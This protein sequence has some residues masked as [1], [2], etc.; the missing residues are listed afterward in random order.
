MGHR[1]G[2]QRQGC[3]PAGLTCV[4]PDWPGEIEAVLGHVLP[5]AF[6]TREPAFFSGIRRLRVA[7]VATALALTALNLAGLLSASAAESGPRD[8]R[9]A[10]SPQRYLQGQYLY[11]RHCVTCHGETGDGRGELAAGMFP[12][13]RPF[14]D[15]VFK[16]RSTPPGTLPTDE[17]LARTIAGGLVGTSMPTFSQLSQAEILALVEYVK[18]FSRRW[19]NKAN[20][21]TPV[22]VPKLPAWFSDR[23][24]FEQQQARGGLLA[25]T[26]CVPCHGE[27]NDGK[28]DA[29]A[30]LLDDWG[31]RSVPA[32]LR[33]TL[34]RVGSKP[35]DLYRLLLTGIGG[36]PMPSY[37]ETL[38]DD[39]R[40]GLV[41][42]LL[43]L[44]GQQ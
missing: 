27:K 34:T 6:R 16:Y 39:E 31:E 33:Q 37:A 13:P 1:R 12:K 17:D 4:G 24:Q 35:E 38:K 8:R 10:S 23:D 19:M 29:A 15:G 2:H 5:T 41:A 44:R 22:R 20:L 43:R 9:G 30:S 7:S 42:W 21:G 32:D 14:K 3:R 11:A 28:G 36:T 18:G 40:W 25:K 26:A